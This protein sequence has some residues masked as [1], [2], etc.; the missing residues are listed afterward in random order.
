MTA[1]VASGAAVVEVRG[2]QKSFGALEVLR[3]V[4]LDEQGQKRGFRRCVH[5]GSF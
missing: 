2:L 5:C 4:D 1:T 3:G